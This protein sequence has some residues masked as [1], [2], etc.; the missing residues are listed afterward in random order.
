MG[1]EVLW[2]SPIQFLIVGGCDT[3]LEHAFTNLIN[4]FVND[5]LKNTSS[6]LVEENSRVFISGFCWTTGTDNL[7]TAVMVGLE[8]AAALLTRP[9]PS[10][11][12]TR[13]IICPASKISLKFVDF[14]IICQNF[15]KITRY[16]SNKMVSKTFNPF[17]SKLI[18]NMPFIK[19]KLFILRRDQPRF[20][21]SSKK[22]L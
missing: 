19:K 18:I 21:K 8:L 22:P 6:S 5:K 11:I 10:C 4:P 2:A 1:C 12:W 9:H 14:K 15:Y 13:S 17:Y 20:D 3:P 7:R 16:L